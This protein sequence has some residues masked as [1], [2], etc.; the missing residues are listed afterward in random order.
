MGPSHSRLLTP[1]SLRSRLAHCR[2]SLTPACLGPCC[3]E[4]PEAVSSA[5]G[6]SSGL[7]L[8]TWHNHSQAVQCFTVTHP[9]IGRNGET[10]MAQQTSLHDLAGLNPHVLSHC[11]TLSW[12]FGSCLPSMYPA[13][14]SFS[15]TMAVALTQPKAGLSQQISFFLLF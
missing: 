15:C 10:T 13:H 1:P 3:Q 4:L 14:G 11:H 6:L 5:S 7:A 12:I 8:K 2:H 9:E